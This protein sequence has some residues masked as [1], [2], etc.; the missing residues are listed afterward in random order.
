M[1]TANGNAIAGGALSAALIDL[2]VSKGVLESTEVG[3]LAAN[4]IARLASL[5]P[6]AD[7]Q[8]AREALTAI[9][10]MHAGRNG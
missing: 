3:G 7:V 6:S 10:Q 8:S 9:A 4:A 1:I 2:L 5:A